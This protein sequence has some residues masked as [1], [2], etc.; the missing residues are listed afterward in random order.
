MMGICDSSG[1]TGT[2]GVFMAFKEYCGEI[3]GERDVRG[4]AGEDNGGMT[5]GLFWT[6]ED[7]FLYDEV[8]MY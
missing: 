5:G 4:C 2:G 7:L 3:L 8:R 1:D 6:E